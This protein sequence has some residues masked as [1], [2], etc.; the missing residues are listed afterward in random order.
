MSGRFEGRLIRPQQTI[1]EITR[2]VAKHE[3]FVLFGVTSWTVLFVSLKMSV[4]IETE[5]VPSFGSA[6]S[7][8][9]R[10]VSAFSAP[11]VNHRFD[12]L[13]AEDAEYV[14]ETQRISKLGT[15]APLD[16]AAGR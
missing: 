7:V 6:L 1:H 4:L 10:I 5:R 3:F 12:K 16:Q 8:L 15:T 14:E 9:L 2:S 13:T 11:S